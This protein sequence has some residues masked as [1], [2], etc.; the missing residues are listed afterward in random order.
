[1]ITLCF[2]AETF[3]QRPQAVRKE[4]LS[5]SKRLP[6]WQKDSEST[7][8]PVLVHDPVLQLNRGRGHFFR[9]KN[10]VLSFH[11][12]ELITFYYHW[13]KTPE[14]AGTRA[15]RQQRR[16]PSSRKAKTRSAAAPVNT[17]SRNYSGQHAQPLPRQ[18]LLKLC[19]CQT[20][21][22]LKKINK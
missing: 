5:Y 22:S 4:F 11:Q 19:L 14:A 12:G 1:M 20:W 6:A 15:Y 17:P 8:P 21:S 16:Q 13:K 18:T 10:N 2:P 3:H 7:P 9:R